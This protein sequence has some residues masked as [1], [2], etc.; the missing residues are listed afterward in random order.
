LLRAIQVLYNDTVRTAQD[1]FD[2][3][4]NLFPPTDHP[5]LPSF[6]FRYGGNDIG[7]PPIRWET[8]EELD[9]H[10]NLFQAQDGQKISELTLNLTYS[11]PTD[12]DPPIPG[13][14]GWKESFVTSSYISFQ[15]PGEES[16]RIDVRD[17]R[18]VMAPGDDRWYIVDWYELP[19]SAPTWGTL[20]AEFLSHPIPPSQPFFQVDDWA[21]WSP[22]G[23]T[24]AYH[25]NVVS[26]D[27]PAGVYLIRADGTDTRLLIEGNWFEPRQLRFSPN[28][29]LLSMTIN[30]EIY[31]LDVR[32]GKLRQLTN[33]NNNA[34]S[35]DWSPDS[36]G[37]VYQRSFRR[38]AQD[39]TGLY[40]I[41]IST[42]NDR[43]LVHNGAAISGGNP[44][45]SPLDEIAF[46]S[47]NRDG[48]VEIFKVSPDGLE[49]SRLTN[50]HEEYAWATLP[51]WFR[52]G[53]QILYT[54][55]ARDDAGR[56]ETRVV[57]SDGK[58]AATWPLY[59]GYFDAVSSDSRYAITPAPQA[60]STWVLFIREID[61]VTGATL[62]QL[63]SYAPA[64]LVVGET[65]SP[66]FTV[67]RQGGLTHDPRRRPRGP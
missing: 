60:D 32:T 14:K 52:G 28:G 30:F 56:V 29:T 7:A 41:G 17:T 65:K 47:G 59:L 62:R 36:S 64:K 18:F 37:I 26:S 23:S 33:T 38:S 34:Q 61:D 5:I 9:V 50:A 44:T 53:T 24:I 66:P 63:T 12:L 15:R 55:R 25:R 20:K 58:N 67:I 21:A 48:D 35:A 10:R 16:V 40:I 51:R 27:G 4:A 13:R 2:A 22:D 42:A 57:D 43:L 11:H 46:S 45:W 6:V 8:A 31:L 39:T 3:Y 54:W 49:L 1:R 19:A